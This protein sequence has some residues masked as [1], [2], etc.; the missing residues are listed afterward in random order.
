MCSQEQ[1]QDGVNSSREGRCLQSSSRQMKNLPARMRSVLLSP[2][3]PAGR[4]LCRCSCA[5]HSGCGVG[6]K[7]RSICTGTR[8]PYPRNSLCFFFLLPAEF[9]KST[10]KHFPIAKCSFYEWLQLQTQ[11]CHE[12]LCSH[13]CLRL[14][15]RL[16]HLVVIGGCLWNSPQDSPKSPTAVSLRRGKKP[17]QTKKEPKKGRKKVPLPKQRPN[18]R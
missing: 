9:A 6:G 13:S 12:R 1:R 18:N 8:W 16:P 14:G 2:L 10:S 7:D 15:W 4:G 17:I 3:P 11:S 5:L